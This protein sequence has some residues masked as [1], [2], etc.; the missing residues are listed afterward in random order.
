MRPRSM[1]AVLFALVLA[2]PAG[3]QQ[4]ML[5]L[6]PDDAAAAILLRH[7]N[8]LKAKGDKFIKDSGLDIG[9]RPSEVFD[10]AL[11]FLGIAKGVDFDRPGGAI[12]LR[13]PNGNPFRLGDLEDNLLLAIP[14]TDLDAM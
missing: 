3:A 1:L 5:D 14:I 7:P 10:Q 2:A 4:T 11:G 12:L 9:F 8:D 13:S 6:I